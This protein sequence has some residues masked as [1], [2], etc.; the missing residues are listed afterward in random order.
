MPGAYAVNLKEG[1]RS[2]ILADYLFSQWGAVTPVRR[3]D[4]IGIDLYCALADQIG[5][6]GV[7]REYF[8]VQVKS[9][10]APWEFKDPDSVR[11]LV[12]YPT[13]LFLACVEKKNGSV[14]VY[15]LMPRFYL[16]AL[17]K[18]PERLE[19]R[20]EASAEGQFVQWDSG[21]SFSLSAPII[22]ATCGDLPDGEKMERLREVFS[23][24]VGFDRENIDLVR[25]GLL[26]FRMPA[27]YRTNQISNAGTIEAGS[28]VPERRFI[29]RGIL[30]LAESA[31][32]IA[33]QVLRQ[34]DVGGALRAALLVRHLCNSYPEVF[35]Q[36]PRW[37]GGT[38]GGLGSLF[39]RLNEGLRD[40]GGPT[41]LF[42]GIDEI[43]KALDE[44]PIVK[45]LL[46][47]TKRDGSSS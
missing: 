11:W 42:Q 20:P 15:H 44:N 2:E 8:T 35:E 19:L 43:A 9:D 28:L 30:R 13:P 47:T 5:S 31:E 40:V 22:R 12:E 29:N 41:Y 26:R 45:T 1:S 24:W 7:V 17:G 6:L 38:P 23:Y 32:C 39:S 3:Q 46:A 14:S 36:H 16:R 25:Q 4:D 18:L 34:G 27:S 10:T 21:E 33:D 37:S